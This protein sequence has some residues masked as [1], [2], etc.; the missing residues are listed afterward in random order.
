MAEA[1]LEPQWDLHPITLQSLC[2]SRLEFVA[3]ITPRGLTEDEWTAS[4]WR[5]DVKSEVK[6]QTA[7]VKATVSHVFEATGEQAEERPPVLEAPYDFLIEARGEFSFDQKVIGTEEVKQW[8]EKGSFFIF[9]P[10][11]RNMIADITRESGFPEVYLPL[12]E[13]PTFRAPKKRPT[14]PKP[15]KGKKKGGGT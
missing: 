6:E 9:A 15:K 11:L 10:Y 8:C 5:I 13:V 3:H 1:S 14:T 2:L 4:K 12:L 7:T